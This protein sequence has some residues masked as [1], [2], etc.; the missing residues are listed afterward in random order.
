MELKDYLHFYE[1][2]LCRWRYVDYH[3]GQW[4]VLAPLTKRDIARLCDDNSVEKIEL[5]IRPLSN[6]TEEEGFELSEALGV[7]T[8]ANFMEAINKGSKYVIDYRNSFEIT[9]YLLSRHFDLFGLIEAGLAIDK[10]KQ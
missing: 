4:S 3:P 9:R 5:H 1:G 10:T 2:A 8:P 6:M 7:F